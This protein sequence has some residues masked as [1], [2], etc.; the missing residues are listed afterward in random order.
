[1]TDEDIVWIRAYNSVYEIRAR[2]NN[3][4]HV[5]IRSRDRRQKFSLSR[6]LS[7]SE[8][9]FVDLKQRARLRALL[10]ST[11]VLDRADSTTKKR[12]DSRNN[13][14]RNDGS[15]SVNANVVWS[16]RYDHV[17][18]KIDSSHAFVGEFNMNMNISDSRF[19]N[20]FNSSNN[21]RGVDT[22][23]RHDARQND[24]MSHP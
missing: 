17:S 4:V 22:R 5:P 6:L 7:L 13:R 14:A 2:C 23:R 8:R 21:S 19:M 16:M 18:N 12:V 24:S 10:A 9:L 15:K 1:M 11:T 20:Q 3:S